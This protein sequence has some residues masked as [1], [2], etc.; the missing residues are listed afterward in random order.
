MA[1]DKVFVIQN[2]KGQ[3][4]SVVDIV[5][6]VDRIEQDGSGNKS[7]HAR[8][9]IAPRFD[10]STVTGASKFSTEAD[11]TGMMAHP[12]LKDPKAFDGCT[13]V[14]ADTLA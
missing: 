1:R 7:V 10:A 2:A 14:D 12:D 11:A 3:L 13:V 6:T 5:G 8:P 9:I 4:Y